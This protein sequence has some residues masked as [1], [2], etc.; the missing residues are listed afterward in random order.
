[1][2]VFGKQSKLQ[3]LKILILNVSGTK[4]QYFCFVFVGRKDLNSFD[5]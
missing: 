1:M 2:A 5:R 4:R 3:N